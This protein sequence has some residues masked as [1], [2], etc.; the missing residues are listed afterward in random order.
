MK[1]DNVPQD[2]ENILEGKFGMLQYA[3]DKDGNYVGIPSKGWEPEN[4]ALKQ[5][6]EVI[7]ERVEDARNQVLEGKASP[8]LFH[9]EKHLMDIKLLAEHVGFFRWTVKRHFKP[10]VFA[11]LSESTLEKYARVFNITQQQL[12]SV[13]E[14]NNL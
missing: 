7:N 13:E 1:K 5:A 2:D 6:W 14:E 4:A 10:T 9:M 8:L 3:T 11:K 12:K